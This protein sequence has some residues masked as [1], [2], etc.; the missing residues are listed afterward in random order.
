[1]KTMESKEIRSFEPTDCE[2]R[3]TRRGR[4]IEGIGIVFNKLSKDLG[5]F[6]E[7]IKPEAIIGV[8]EQSDVLALLNHDE[9]RGVLARSTNGDGTLELTP[10]NNGVRYRFEAPD[11]ALGDEV[12]SG[13]RRGDIRT[14]SFAFTIAED[15]D[16][17]EK[18]EDDSY[19]RTITKFKQIYDVSPVYREA[20]ADTTVAVRSLVEVRT[21]E[22]EKIAAEAVKKVADLEEELR[23][24]SPLPSTDV[25]VAD[26]VKAED[27]T[28]YFKQLRNKIKK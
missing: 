7:T 23:Q 11:T 5:G 20:Y 4:N 13:I 14:S 17:W 16:K 12:L 28:E 2:V 25:V 10:N 26:P 6:R 15:G 24:K 21:N 19:I 18:Q 22:A 1:M 8:L 9:A 3:A 27:L